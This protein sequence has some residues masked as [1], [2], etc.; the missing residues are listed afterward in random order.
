[1]GELVPVLALPPM[2]PAAI[3]RVCEIERIN[4]T[5][6]QTTLRYKHDLHAGMYARTMIV[7]DLA[8]GEACLITATLIKVPTLVIFCGE[9]LAYTGED[10]T[11]HLSGCDTIRAAAGRQQAFL[12]RSGFRLTMIF[13]TTAK[14]VEEA[15]E[16]FTDEAERLASRHTITVT[17]G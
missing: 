3:S 9:A 1:M 8:P 15:E 13:P 6:P 4:L 10:E 11:L 12:A 16:E 7:P 5:R 14:T 17:G 2:S